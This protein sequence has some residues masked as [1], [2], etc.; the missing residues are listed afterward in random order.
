MQE[1]HIT[2]PY[3][4]D[5]MIFDPSVQQYVLTE[6]ALLSR[7]IDIRA[8]LA[9]TNS[10]TQEGVICNILETASDMVYGY[11]HAFSGNNMR[12]DC[13]IATLPS[14]RN[15]MLRALRYQAV[16]VWYNGDLTLSQDKEERENAVNSKVK[17][18]LERTV[19]EIGTTIL[20]V[21]V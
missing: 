4:D 13:L 10:I 7:G 18:L 11:I 6:K 5:Y 12:Q 19:P 14:M 2:Y 3:D 16:H 21:G 8:Q 15:V 1:Q 17:E 9:E 20:Y